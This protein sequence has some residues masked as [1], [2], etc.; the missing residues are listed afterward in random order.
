MK[1]NGDGSGAGFPKKAKEH[2]LG[3]VS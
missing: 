2:N 1:D 3:V